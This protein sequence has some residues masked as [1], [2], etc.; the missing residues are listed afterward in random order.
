LRLLHNL[1]EKPL[2][3]EIISPRK[4]ITVPELS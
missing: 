2:S 4:T 3:P 1:A